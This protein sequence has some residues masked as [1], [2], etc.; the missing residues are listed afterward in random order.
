MHHFC[1]WE[2]L[3]VFRRREWETLGRQDVEREMNEE[4]CCC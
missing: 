4:S 1:L 3:Q 2:E